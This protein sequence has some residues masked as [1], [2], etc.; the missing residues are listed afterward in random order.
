MGN[1]L[2]LVAMAVGLSSCQSQ[3]EQADAP[4]APPVTASRKATEHPGFV[5]RVWSVAESKQVEKGQIYIFASTGALFITSPHGK[6]ATGSWTYEN[7]TL[8]MIEDAPIYAKIVSLTASELK[9]KVEKPSPV[10]MTLEPA[11]QP[12]FKN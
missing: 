5:N 7:G 9:L 10:E 6:P 12:A 8:T 2:F 1:V 3:G 11:A 4:S